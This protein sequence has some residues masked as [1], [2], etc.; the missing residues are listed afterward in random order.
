[1]ATQTGRDEEGARLSS[2]NRD[3][4]PENPRA[5]HARRSR[6]L[7]AGSLNE[8]LPENNHRCFLPSHAGALQE[9]EF[10]PSS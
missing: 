1:M 6:V 5:I 4:L 2:A 7:T 3:P 8:E 9:A 10:I